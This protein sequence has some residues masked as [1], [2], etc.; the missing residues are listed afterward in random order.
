MKGYNAKK[1]CCEEK[2]SKYTNKLTLSNNYKFVRSSRIIV[3]PKMEQILI[4]HYKLI[5]ALNNQ[6][7]TT[8]NEIS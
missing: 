5:L 8:D 7:D 1:S 4:S 2:Q 3:Q 6:S